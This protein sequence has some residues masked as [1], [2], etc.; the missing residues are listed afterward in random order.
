[1]RF[2]PESHLNCKINTITYLNQIMMNN[3]YHILISDKRANV[4]LEH[5]TIKSTIIIY[6]NNN[7]TNCTNN[8]NTNSTNYNNNTNSTNNNNNLM[9]IVS[10][11]IMQ[12]VM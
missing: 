12:F 2:L 5:F 10:S 7:N 8:N 11:S 4:L 9:K 6:N 1:M 3:E